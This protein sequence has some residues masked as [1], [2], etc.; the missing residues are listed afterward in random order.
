[1][2]IA[3]YTG[4]GVWLVAGVLAFNLACIPAWF[5]VNHLRRNFEF[6]LKRART[7]LHVLKE[8]REKKR[9]WK[10]DRS[11]DESIARVEQQI[12]EA[13]GKGP[14]WGRRPVA[15]IQL[16]IHQM[17]DRWPELTEKVWLAMDRK[18]QRTTDES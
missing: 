4:W 11:L 13:E 8:E 2:E 17:T 1:M 7:F 14:L 6:E 9:P 15:L 18:A 12:V 5:L 3:G 10:S 16:G